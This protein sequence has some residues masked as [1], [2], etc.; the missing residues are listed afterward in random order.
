MVACAGPANPEKG[1][2]SPRAAFVGLK[3]RGGEEEVKPQG[4]NLRVFA[5][6]IEP[7]RRGIPYRFEMRSG[8]TGKCQGLLVTRAG[9]YEGKLTKRQKAN[10]Y[11]LIRSNLTERAG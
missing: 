8:D 6:G 4:K 5:D 3:N 11:G 9:F 2:C 1:T 10:K 7:F